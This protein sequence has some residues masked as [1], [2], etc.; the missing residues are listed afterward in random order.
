MLLRINLGALSVI[1]L[2]CVLFLPA[3]YRQPSLVEN[4]RPPQPILYDLP[5][6]PARAVF[7]TSS[8]EAVSVARAESVSTVSPPIQATVVT[9]AQTYYRAPASVCVGG[10]RAYTGEEMAYMTSAYEWEGTTPERMAQVFMLENGGCTSTTSSEAA[11]CTQVEWSPE[12]AKKWDFDRIRTS[13]QYAIT[14]A[15]NVFEEYRAIGWNPL[16]AWTASG[17]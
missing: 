8:L 17:E 14:I 3:T 5:S 12:R 15:H 4:A 2:L 11:G 16:H 1:T 6:A 13:C 10:E 9:S 7:A